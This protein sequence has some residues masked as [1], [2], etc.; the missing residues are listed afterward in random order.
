MSTQK[1]SSIYVD[2]V[3]EILHYIPTKNVVGI[4]NGT[5]CILYDNWTPNSVCV[6]SYVPEP[7]Y[8][9]K[10]FLREMFRYPF[11]NVDFVLGVTPGDNTRALAFNKRIGFTEAY[12]LPS[13][14]ARGVDQVFQVMSYKDCR[15]WRRPE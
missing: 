8:L 1:M 5:A 7:R 12:R 6:H 14:F 3:C 13:G 15:Y 11:S 4:R 9:T 2:D 10:G